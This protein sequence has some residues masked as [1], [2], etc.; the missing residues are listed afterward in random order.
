MKILFFEK[1][2]GLNYELQTRIENEIEKIYIEYL[3]TIASNVN[4]TF[5]DTSKTFKF[6]DY[7]LL[8]T[9]INAVMLE[10]NQRVRTSIMNGI[11]K[12]WNLSN[13]ANNQFIKD[14]FKDRLATKDI[15]LRYNNQNLEA[16][17]AFQER[18]SKGLNLSDRVWNYTNQFKSDIELALDVALLEGTSAI[19]LASTLKKYLREP[20]KLF[21]RVR[22]K[23]GKLVLSKNAK[24]YNSGRGVYRS[25]VRNAQRLAR[26]EINMAY[27]QAEFNRWS[28]ID[29]I[30]AI[31]IKRSN[32]YYK[33]DI[34]EPLKGIYPKEFLFRG[35][36]PNCRCFAIPIM[37]N[38]D[39]FTKL[40][41]F[42]AR[43]GNPKDFEIQKSV[44][45]PPQFN[46]WIQDNEKRSFGSN[47]PYFIT[48][49]LEFV[50]FSKLSV[51]R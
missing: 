44:Q 26:T 24:A 27:R 7:Q 4:A 13:K 2:E 40:T 22:D 28:E 9:K 38:D 42:I 50:N 47:I 10:I 35:W 17:K 49:N 16:L 11:E 18:K 6:S 48:D 36:H 19:K 39:E 1:M 37:F 33:C 34:C 51:A 3:Q 12:S 14:I 43:G 20:N 32:R 45:V 29:F 8:N 46:Q 15:P 31:E 41:Q 25:S 5:I 30:Y 23:N 21:R